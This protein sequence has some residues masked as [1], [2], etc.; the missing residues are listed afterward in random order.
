M[1]SC[2]RSKD[3]GLVSGL[4]RNSLY[5]CRRS[6]LASLSDTSGATDKCPVL[7]QPCRM[8]NVGKVTFLAPIK[9]A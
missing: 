9:S 5:L 3:T 1:V 6:A 2:P 8:S 7:I 4:H